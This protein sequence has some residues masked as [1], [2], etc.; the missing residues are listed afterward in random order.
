[1]DKAQL[2]QNALNFA[3]QNPDSPEAVELRKRIES[4]MYTKEL[5]QIKASN[6]KIQSEGA[7]ANAFLNKSLAG[8]IFSKETLKELPG[9]AGEIVKDIVV[10]TPVKIL[11]SSV[12]PLYQAGTAIAGDMKNIPGTY[13]S[14]AAET[15]GKIIEG[16]KPLYTALA[17]FVEVPLDVT[18][19]AA[20]GVGGTKIA[21][22]TV[23]TVKPIVSEQISKIQVR[24]A[25]KAE[26]KI[27][28]K[29]T[30]K[31]NELTP[32][33]YQDLLSKGKI[34]P[35][36]ATQP[37]QYVLSDAE[38]EVARKNAKLL[39]SNDPVKNSINIVDDIAKKDA[40]VGEFLKNN[41]GIYNNGELKN[42]ILKNMEDIT[43]IT[44]DD[45]RLLAKKQ[46]MVDNFIK[47]LNK[48]DME[49][50]WKERKAF[51][52]E[53]EKAFS[54]SPT[55]QNQIKR[56]FRNAVQDFIAERTPEGVYKGY[57]K[58][59]RELFDLLDVVKTKASKE[60]TLNALQLWAKNN[61]T[62]TNVLK[63]VGLSG[64]GGT[65]GYK[66]FNP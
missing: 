37:A 32:T 31:T 46:Q 45:A 25:L 28:E 38:K 8:Q 42:Y 62:K 23:E 20:L 24:R 36:T 35:K 5:N 4:G 16:E 17:P 22:K 57:M 43:D 12:N 66:I 56:S 1:M 60:K 49:N 21:K 47:K 18:S 15:A 19:T 7:A 64:L 59:M 40:E 65:I 26:E 11:K 34:T 3:K 33:E 53:I 61:P 14:E 48:N 50:L 52:R 13:Q 6:Q 9:K 51:D 41:N 58:D 63:W 29:V 2:L 39:T 30:P 55:L 44:I 54:G 10:D 27:F